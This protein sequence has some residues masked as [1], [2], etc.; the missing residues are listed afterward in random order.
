MFYHKICIIFHFCYARSATFSRQHVDK[1]FQFNNIEATK[2]NFGYNL[3]KEFWAVKLNAKIMHAMEIQYQ[4]A[5]NNKT[6][7]VRQ[8]T[9]WFWRKRFM[10]LCVVKFNVP[11]SHKP[12]HRDNN[13]S[14]TRLNIEN[15]MNVMWAAKYQKSQVVIPS[16][17]IKIFLIHVMISCSVQ[18]WREEARI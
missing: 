10:N 15:L 3:D 14:A 13:F 5:N 16:I 17:F 2:E 11:K 4:D 1:T 6:S 9:T 8:R 7:R 12:W 18:Q